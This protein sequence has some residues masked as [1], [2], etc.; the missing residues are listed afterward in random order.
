M[1][2]TCTSATCA[3]NSTRTAPTRSY[4]PSVVLGTCSVRLVDLPRTTSFQLALRFLLLFGAASL[5]LFVFLYCQTAHYVSQR[6]DDWLQREQA[7]FSVSDQADL[8][9]RLAAHLVADP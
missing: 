4:A 3:A 5:A 7:I 6:I 1:S 8:Q 2:S 9:R